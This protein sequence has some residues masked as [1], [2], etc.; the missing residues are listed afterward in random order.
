MALA[1]VPSDAGLLVLQAGVVAAPRAVSSL[2]RLDRLRGRG[3]ALVPLGSIVLVVFAIRYVSDT[4]TGLTYLALVAVPLLA[5]AA[6][7]WTMRGARPSAAA[8]AVVL[9]ALAWAVRTSLL[10]EASAALLSAL[11]CVTLGVLLAAVT[12]PA[13]LKA[14][15]I[16]MAAADSWLVI[17]D[18][19]QAPNATLIAAHPAAGLP[20]LQSELFGTVSM[21]YG[22]LFVAALLG[23]VLARNVRQQRAAAVLTLAIAAVFDLLF[24]VINELP[25]TVP[26]ALALIVVEGWQWERGRRQRAGTR[27]RPG[28]GEGE[29]EGEGDGRRKHPI[30]EPARTRV[31]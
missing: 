16:L 23:A 4:A 25:A 26:V 12:P 19:L 31:L 11:S 10:G 15:I 22:D 27:E 30:A 2:A 1:F 18:L 14:G 20:Q 5:A 9:F 17:G 8:G 24:L 28:D 29:G 7:G 21:G 13:W 3:W 6:L